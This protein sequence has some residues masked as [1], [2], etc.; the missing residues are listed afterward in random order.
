MSDNQD[1]TSFSD[2]QVPIK[3]HICLF[4]ED[5]NFANFIRKSLDQS[6]YLVTRI[7]N[8]N[9]LIQLVQNQDSRNDDNQK[10]TPFDCLV[11]NNETASYNLISQLRHLG[12]VLPTAIAYKEQDFLEEKVILYHSAEV[13]FKLTTT[14]SI[15]NQINLALTKF[16][17]LSPHDSFAENTDLESAKEQKLTH[18]LLSLQQKRLA[19]KLKERLGYLGIYYKRNSQDFY[20]NLTKSQQKKFLEE[21]AAEYRKII[22]SYFDEEL[23]INQT[24]D[25][26]VNQAFFA[27]IS[28]SQILEIHMELM[29][30]FAQQLKLEGRNEDIL[31]DYRLALIDII[32][33][34][35]E[36]YR[37][38]IPKE[39]IP[40]E[41][42]FRV[43]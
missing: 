25:R 16:L 11:I 26:F 4:T 2:R 19:E 37:R 28:V 32:A 21:L 5:D 27:D 40:L 30:E 10:R 20:R 35:C 1:S 8:K 6:S 31:L 15:S 34:L 24:I 23:N 22:L 7:A 3:L 39:D 12:I 13:K 43:D 42:L 36:M 33:H 9:A 14:E 38:C 17:N 29:D 18:N 41:V